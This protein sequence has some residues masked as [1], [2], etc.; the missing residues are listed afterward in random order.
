[1]TAVG[2]VCGEL[3]TRHGWCRPR[4]RARR[5]WGYESRLKRL[6]SELGTILE[7]PARCTP[8]EIAVHQT[9]HR[10]TGR[11]MIFVPLGILRRAIRSDTIRLAG[12]SEA[13]AGSIAGEFRAES[14][15]RYGELFR[16]PGIQRPSASPLGFVA[17]ALWSH[18]MIR[19]FAPVLLLTLVGASLISMGT[20]TFPL[21]RRSRGGLSEP[22]RPGLSGN[23]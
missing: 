11:R 16:D 9:A 22:R 12:A 1:M 2:G 5:H 23:G 4:Q 10:S 21:V 20:R 7:P 3:K 8:F 6:E 14:P 17:F 13:S 18:K 19:W 15:D